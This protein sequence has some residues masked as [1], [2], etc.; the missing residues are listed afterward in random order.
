MKLAHKRDRGKTPPKNC[1]PM[2]KIVRQKI[3]K[4]NPLKPL[5]YS[6]KMIERFAKLLSFCLR[7]KLECQA[8]FSRIQ[9]ERREKAFNLLQLLF[10]HQV[11][12]SIRKPQN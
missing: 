4:N 12:K 7:E 3:V 1:L 8:V 9:C 6:I 11:L 2:I 5:Y 10:H